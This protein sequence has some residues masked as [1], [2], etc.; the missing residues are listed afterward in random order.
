MPIRLVAKGGVQIH[1]FVKKLTPVAPVE[2]DIPREATKTG[3]L[4]LEWTLPPGLGGNGRG[5]HVA[6]VWLIRKK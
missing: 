4:T 2:F 6:G 3:T 5:N 1:D